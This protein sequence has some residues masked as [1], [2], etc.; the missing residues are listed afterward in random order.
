MA[1]FGRNYEQEKKNKNP[2]GDFKIPVEDLRNLVS[3]GRVRCADY[4]SAG[5]NQCT[6][7]DGHFFAATP[8]R[9]DHIPTVLPVNLHPVK[10]LRMHVLHTLSTIIVGLG[11]QLSILVRLL[12]VPLLVGLITRTHKAA[13]TMGIRH[14]LQL[15]LLQIKE[16][17]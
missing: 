5:S 2:V 17:Q 8:T 4:S 7:V 10:T 11:R 9:L 3:A 1:I 6:Q 12:F 16:Y 13:G 14:L 15:V